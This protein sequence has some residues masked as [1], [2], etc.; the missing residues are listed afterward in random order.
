MNGEEL[1]A[2]N[3][4]VKNI[5]IFHVVCLT[6]K[7]EAIRVFETAVFHMASSPSKNNNIAIN[8]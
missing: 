7:M 2:V 3:N 6:L 5:A 4:I 1:K 8:S